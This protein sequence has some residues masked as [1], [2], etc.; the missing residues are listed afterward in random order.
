M[1]NLNRYRNKQWSAT[2]HSYDQLD[3]RLLRPEDAPTLRQYREMLE[4]PQSCFYR[5]LGGWMLAEA[6]LITTDAPTQ[7]RHELLEKAQED[8]LIAK[9]IQLQ[10]DQYKKS[11]RHFLPGVEMLRIDNNLAA[12]EVFHAMIDGNITAEHRARYY[13]SL[14]YLGIKASE[15][16]DFF[17][18]DAPYDQSEPGAENYLGVAH[19]INASLAI[20]RLNSP[21]LMSF[22]ALPRADSG[23]YHPTKTH[24]LQVFKMHWGNIED[25]LAAEV[26]TTLQDHH[27]QRY[28]AVLIG[29]S[30]HLHPQNQR[31]PV[32]MTRLM[33]KE[34][35]GKATPE[36]VAQ[37]DAITDNVVHVAR[38]G[39]KGAPQCRNIATCTDIPHTR[40]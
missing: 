5:Q 8:W 1:K 26:K 36:E 12:S 6:A 28:E 27:Y 10:T 13:E 7:E 2:L 32:A 19:E 21:T 16:V 30:L 18:Q 40:K 24:D 11:H 9:D 14:L 35:T 31:S 20:N 34:F 15:A 23:H 37:L 38:H 4:Q 3:K 22:P 29:G 39:F 33:A 17:R 25:I